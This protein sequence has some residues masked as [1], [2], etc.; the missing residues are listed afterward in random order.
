MIDQ[1]TQVIE[2]VVTWQEVVMDLGMAIVV[3]TPGSL[4]AYWTFRQNARLQ[5]I[6]EASQQVVHEVKQVKATMDASTVVIDR[7]VMEAT[8]YPNHV[9]EPVSIVPIHAPENR[10]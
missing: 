3:A 6:H 2:H 1:V 9:S 4:A 10:P 7:S 8:P 5:A